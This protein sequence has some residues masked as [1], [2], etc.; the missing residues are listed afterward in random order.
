MYLALAGPISN[1]C[2]SLTNIA[3]WAPICASDLL[4]RFELEKVLLM[5]DF[6]V[7][8]FGLLKLREGYYVKV[9]GEMQEQLG[10]R[11][12]VVMGPGTGLGVGKRGIM[13][14]FD[15]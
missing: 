11:M 2:C 13:G 8:A 1:L 3:K 12:R 9:C 15:F 10:E 5:N 6:E 4:Q 14:F 7:N